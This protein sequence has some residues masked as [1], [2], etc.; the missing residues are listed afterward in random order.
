MASPSK[1][2]PLPSA[3]DPSRKRRH[4]EH[5]D[6]ANDIPSTKR[7]CDEVSI[8]TSVL[9]EHAEKWY[10]SVEI[11]IEHYCRQDPQ[12]KNTEGLY[13]ALASLNR[14]LVWRPRGC[15]HPLWIEV[16]ETARQVECWKAG[17][18]TWRQAVSRGRTG[19][20]PFIH[21]P[22]WL[23]AT[24]FLNIKGRGIPCA[25]RAWLRRAEL[26]FLVVPNT[27]TPP[28]WRGAKFSDDA[29]RR[30]FL[31]SNLNRW[32]QRMNIP[33]ADDCDRLAG[34]IRTTIKEEQRLG[35]RLWLPPKP[36]TP[37]QDLPEKRSAADENESPETEEEDDD[38]N[39]CD[40]D[41]NETVWSVD[42]A[43]NDFMF[44]NRRTTH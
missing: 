33:T 36:S 5:D 30:R 16:R 20:M 23:R 8:A 4:S 34:A 17:H 43:E 19:K 14:G 1:P 15:A 27:R 26:D 11:I 31:D 10:L 24:R 28:F 3:M 39:L 6:D 29:W 21:H 13:F 41:D 12:V 18:N 37:V 38:A 32:A 42:V 9:S 35:K 2:S 7:P 25:L 44:I 40:G 22:V